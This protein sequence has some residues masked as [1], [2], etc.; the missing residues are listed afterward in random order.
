MG[1]KSFLGFGKTVEGPIDH[2]SEATALTEWALG[3]FDN[4]KADLSDA[5]NHLAAV[6]AEAV[7]EI[8]RF[9]ARHDQAHTTQAKNEH[10]IGK[11]ADFLG[12][13]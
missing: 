2:L 6:K 8:A 13:A 5:N 11:L 4:V 7:S 10:V 12:E 1:L 9:Q 3:A